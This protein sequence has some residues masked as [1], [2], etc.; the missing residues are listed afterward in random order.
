[1]RCQFAPRSALT[2]VHFTARVIPQA[3][4]Q[5]LSGRGLFDD[6]GMAFELVANCGR[7]NGLSK[8][9]RA[10]RGKH[11]ERSARNFTQTA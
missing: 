5:A 10:I 8:G 7:E 4:I 3:E 9:V 11:P 2:D 6:L 1:M